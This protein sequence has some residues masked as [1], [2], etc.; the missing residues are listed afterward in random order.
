MSELIPRCF[1]F[2]FLGYE[3]S[4]LDCYL[5]RLSFD[6]ISTVNAEF[7][8]TAYENEKFFNVLSNSVCTVDGQIPYWIAKYRGVNSDLL[9]KVSGSSYVEHVLDLCFSKGLKVFLLGGKPTSINLILDKYSGNNFISGYS[10]IFEDYPFSFSND[11]LIKKTLE[12]F[13]PDILLVGFGAVKQE[14]WIYD[15]KEY[16]SSIGVRTAIGVGGS[17]E[18]LSGSLPRAP[19]FIQKIGLE[20][21]YRLIQQPSMFRLK[22]ILKSLNVFIYMN[23]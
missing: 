5:L 21:L 15:N 16:L 22:R 19:F 20:S 9:S 17:F 12:E 13:K 10:P 7:I 3:Q 18:F 8:V 11:T 14:F 2:D 23:K 6:Q 4:V 1:G